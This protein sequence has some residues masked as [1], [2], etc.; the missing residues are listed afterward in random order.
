MKILYFDCFSGIAG[1]MVLGSLI[2]AGLDIDIL[3]RELKKLK[4]K[5][6]GLKASRVMRGELSGTKLDVIVKDPALTHTHRSLAYILKLIDDS[7]LNE[8]IKNDA[9]KIF[10]LIAKAESG[11]HGVSAGKVRLH[12]LGEIDSIVDIVGCAI[13]VDAL[14]IEQIYSSVVNLGRTIINSK[15]GVLPV[16][17]PASLDILKGVPVKILDIEAELVTPTGS[18][19]LK[20][21]SKGFGKMPQMEISSVG[22]G[23][24]A[25]E[26]AEIP[27]MLRVI[28]GETVKAFSEDSI[29]VA[30]TNIDDMNP[31]NFE[32]L[33]ERLLKGGA[34]DVYTANIQMKK[35]RPAFKLTV[36][37]DRTNLKKLSSIIFSETTSSGIR[38]YEAARFKL[39]RKT[40][41]VGTRFGRVKVKLNTGPGDILTASPEYEECVKLARANKVPLKTVYD[42]ARYNLRRSSP[43]IGAIKS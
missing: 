7:S 21:L 27:N 14:G 35:S 41:E 34:L 9:K 31:Q 11:I 12:E 32:Y 19:I 8:R 29:F 6:I 38:Y 22:Y 39:E 3:S 24:G 13:A 1:D 10:N 25:K 4:V 43:K 30:E 40:A 18:G 15:G 2:D 42:E 33:F 28:I 20:A 37:A 17:S 5:G 16:P 36:L 23:A 26:L